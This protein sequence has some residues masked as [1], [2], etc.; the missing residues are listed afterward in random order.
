MKNV[1]IMARAK[2]WESFKVI[3][4]TKKYEKVG[5]LG[6]DS[7][8]H[9]HVTLQK[10]D[11][12]CGFWCK[13]IYLCAHTCAH[14]HTHTHTHNKGDDRP[15]LTVILSYVEPSFIAINLWACPYM[16]LQYKLTGRNMFITR[17]QKAHTDT[18]FSA[19][20]KWWQQPFPLKRKNS[21]N[22]KKIYCKLSSDA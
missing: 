6:Q 14:T 3:S 16:I 17:F 22:T 5:G 21:K 1:Q 9:P 4:L 10:I 8:Q 20:G 12:K 2:R 18:M 13:R 19:D 11:F 15:Y 7:E